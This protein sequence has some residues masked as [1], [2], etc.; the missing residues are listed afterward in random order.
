MAVVKTTVQFDTV[1]YW[2][3]TI[4][5]GVRGQL[6]FNQMRKFCLSELAQL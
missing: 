2:N 4:L 5:T 6:L 3:H 1:F